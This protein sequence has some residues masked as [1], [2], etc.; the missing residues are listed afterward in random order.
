MLWTLFYFATEI[1]TSCYQQVQIHLFQGD[2]GEESHQIHLCRGESHLS[3]TQSSPQLVHQ[4]MD[5]DSHVQ[6]VLD[7]HFGHQLALLHSGLQQLQFVSCFLERLSGELPVHS[8]RRWPEI[9]SHCPSILVIISCF[10]SEFVIEICLFALINFQIHLYS[11]LHTEKPG[12]SHFRS[13]LLIHYI[14]PI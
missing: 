14:N 9:S 8:L 7:A 12:D 4:R 6:V 10:H 13:L 1:D 5:V 2:S 3:H 11:V